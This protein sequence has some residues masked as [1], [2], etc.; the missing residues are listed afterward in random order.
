MTRFPALVAD[1]VRPDGRTGSWWGGPQKVGT[2]GLFAMTRGGVAIAAKAQSG[3]PEVA[4]AAALI[5]ADTIGILPPAMADALRDQIQP[6]VIG[7]GRTVGRMEL[8]EA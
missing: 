8:I 1:N 6:L 3:R 7:G 5:T 2:E 4:V